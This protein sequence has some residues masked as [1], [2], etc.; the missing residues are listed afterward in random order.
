MTHKE[1]EQAINN[2]LTEIYRLF[3]AKNDQYAT[4]DPLA[5]FTRGAMLIG[6]GVVNPATQFEALKCYV[7]KH[8]AHVYNNRLNGEKVDESIMDIAVYFIIASVM[9]DMQKAREKND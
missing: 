3:S 9:A 2:K 6:V 1:F 8:I 4:N 7:L 5:N